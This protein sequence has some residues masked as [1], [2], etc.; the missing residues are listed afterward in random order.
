MLF[1]FLLIILLTQLEAFFEAQSGNMLI[2]R[3]FFCFSIF[4]GFHRLKC[5]SYYFSVCQY[6]QRIVNTS[7][8]FHFKIFTKT[9]VTFTQI[10][11][12]TSFFLEIPLKLIQQRCPFLLPNLEEKLA[13]QT[14]YHTFLKNRYPMDFKNPH[15][16]YLGEIS[17]ES[18]IQISSSLP[19]GCLIWSLKFPVYQELIGDINDFF[20]N[21]LLFD[22]YL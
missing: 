8:R 12:I 9:K 10:N 19:I 16:S 5:Y 22:Y 20:S 3:F 2:N 13:V 11:N 14:I 21:L 7:T 1:K 17:Q 15:E 4:K 6:F 18:K